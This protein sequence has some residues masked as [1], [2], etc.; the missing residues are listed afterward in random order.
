MPTRLRKSPGHHRNWIAR[1]WPKHGPLR[2]L[3]AM[4]DIRDPEFVILVGQQLTVPT[5]G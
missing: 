3:A 1:C 5:R 2:E 4:N